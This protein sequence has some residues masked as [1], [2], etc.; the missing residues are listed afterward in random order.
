MVLTKDTADHLMDLLIDHPRRIL[1]PFNHILFT[2]HVVECL[3]LPLYRKSLQ[4]LL[5]SAW[6]KSLWLL[7]VIVAKVVQ[8]FEVGVDLFADSDYLN[9]HFL[10][11]LGRFDFKSKE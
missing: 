9:F 1:R 6:S 8:L 11:L 3:L 4:I 10:H 7:L 2:E 5:L